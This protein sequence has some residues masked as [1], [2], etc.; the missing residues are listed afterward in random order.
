MLSTLPTSTNCTKLCWVVTLMPT[1]LLP[2]CQLAN[3]SQ[4]LADIAAAIATSQ[5]AIAAD[6]SN[7][8][9][10]RDLYENVLGREA[11]EEA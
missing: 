3:G 7:G 9:F 8:D 11:E 5:E 2:G 10:V 6:Q 1:A 4:S